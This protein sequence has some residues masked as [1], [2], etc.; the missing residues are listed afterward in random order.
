M[1]EKRWYT[2]DALRSDLTNHH[3]HLRAASEEEVERKM[4]KRYPE[5]VAILVYLEESWR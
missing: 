1:S 5:T 3:H 2:A 4:R